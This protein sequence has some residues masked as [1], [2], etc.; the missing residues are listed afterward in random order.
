MQKTITAILFVLLTNLL[1]AQTNVYNALIQEGDK[2]YS[3]SNY[4]KAFELYVK[5]KEKAINSTQEKDAETKINK[6]RNSIKKQQEDLQ[7]ALNKANIETEKAEK[8]KAKSDSLLRVAEAMQRKVETAMFDKAVKERNKEWKS[9]D[10]YNWDEDQDETKKG[11]EILAGIDSLNLSENALFRIPHEVAECTNLKHVN[12]LQN[13]DLNWDSTFIYIKEK[14]GINS[15]Y[16]S[17]ND[18]SEIDSTYYPFISGIEILKD[19][20][21][22]IPE[23]ILKQ[24]QLRYLDLSGYFDNEQNHF[25]NLNNLFDLIKK[26]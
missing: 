6:S 5:A 10:K 22:A 16:V 3:S 8:A 1:F 25:P 20:L 11:K 4:I 9:Y 7:I 15:V 12:L 18:L 26:K 19:R 2:N 24:K 21:Q 14:T 23:N 17:V 13:K